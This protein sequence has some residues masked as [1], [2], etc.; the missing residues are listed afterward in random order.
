MFCIE[1]SEVIISFMCFSTSNYFNLYVVGI[2]ATMEKLLNTPY[3]KH[4][5]LFY[6]KKSQEKTGFQKF[7][8]CNSSSK[9]MKRSGFFFFFVGVN[10][11]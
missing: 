9:K 3:L 2:I 1:N 7:L 11:F 8:N 6:F 5:W 10:S 4:Q